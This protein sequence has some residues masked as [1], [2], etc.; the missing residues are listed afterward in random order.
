M[1]P[2]LL[3]QGKTLP[4]IQEL[5]L[6]FIE[7]NRHQSV[8]QLLVNPALV[9]VFRELQCVHFLPLVPARTRVDADPAL[10]KVR[11][12][13][14]HTQKRFR[15]MND[16]P[17]DRMHRAFQRTAD[18]GLAHL[19]IHIPGVIDAVPACPSADLPDFLRQERAPLHAVKLVH[20]QHDHPAYGQIHTH[21]YGIRGHH[22]LACAFSELS[23][24]FVPYLV[25][26]RAI[27]NAWLHPVTEVLLNIRRHSM[28]IPP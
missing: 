5:R 7:R 18:H 13:G 22:H 27:D 26:K 9:Q 6:L 25:G 28:H 14:V 24:L 12:N 3:R 2:V 16:R 20:L 19:R 4:Y 8:L 11:Q 21:A 17:G 15:E 23:G 1:L 10:Q